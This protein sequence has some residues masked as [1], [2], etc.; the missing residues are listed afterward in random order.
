MTEGKELM[1]CPWCGKAEF[2]VAWTRVTDEV[3]FWRVECANCDCGANGPDRDTEDE[4]IG[5]WN[6]RSRTLSDSGDD[7]VERVARA[8]MAVSRPNASPDDLTPA[9][10]GQVGL[11]PKWKLFEHLAQAAIAAMRSTPEIVE[12]AECGTEALSNCE[13]CGAPLFQDDDYATDENGVS[14]CW[15][16]MTDDECATDGR[17]CYAHRVGKPSAALNTKDRAHG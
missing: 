8:M 6:T 12:A 15:H 4:A 1:P 11:M 13:Q 17:P 9:P 10:R 3:Q 5:A 2:R 14:G 16:A 7:V